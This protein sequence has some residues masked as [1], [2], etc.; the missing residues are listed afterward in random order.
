MLSSCALSRP[1]VLCYSQWG[2]GPS[3]HQVQTR[4]RMKPGHHGLAVPMCGSV[5]TGVNVFHK[6]F[7]SQPGLG[8]RLGLPKS[9]GQVAGNVEV[10]L[11]GACRTG[12]TLPHCPRP[13]P[14]AAGSEATSTGRGA[15]QLAG[16]CCTLAR[17][18][19][20]F[21]PPS[22]CLLFP[23]IRGATRFLRVLT[24]MRLISPMWPRVFSL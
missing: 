15:R 2:T 14:A 18:L 12:R 5:S 7:I 8:L 21:F 24:R 23:F 13:S 4:P 3:L 17:S 20:P 11:E 1:C 22:L 16:L 9:C 10:P 6:A 19:H